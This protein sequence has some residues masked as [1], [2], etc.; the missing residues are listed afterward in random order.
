[1][2][3]KNEK[4]ISDDVVALVG[5]TVRQLLIKEGAI[6]PEDLTG[7]LQNMIEHSSDAEIRKDCN[8][9]IAQL[10]KKMH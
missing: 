8:E 6:T 1:M 4:H 5:R 10:M 7:E 9:I 2:L 3:K